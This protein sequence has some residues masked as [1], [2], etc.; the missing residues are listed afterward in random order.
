MTDLEH[1]IAALTITAG[2]IAFFV[3]SVILIP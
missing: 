1:I 2:T 3:L